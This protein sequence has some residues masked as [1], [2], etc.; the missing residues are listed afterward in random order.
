MELPFSIRLTV[1]PL[2]LVA[3]AVLLL[4]NSYAHTGDFVARSFELKG[5]TL[6]SV[7]L[8]QPVDISAVKQALQARFGDVAVNELSGL[9]GRSILINVD[10]SVDG[11]DVIAVLDSMGISTKDSSIQTLGATVGATFFSQAQTAMAFAFILMAIII[12]S[13]FREPLPSFYMIFGAFSD[14]IITL[15]FMQLFGIELSLASL[16]ALLMLLGYS[17]DTDIMFTSRA[18]KQKDN[19][20]LMEKL[21]GSFKTGITMT[22]TAIV[23]LA[24]ILIT[25]ISPVL[26]QIASVLIIG[27]AADIV[28]TWFLNAPLLNWYMKKRGRA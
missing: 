8:S 14:M 15:G 6:V 17:I 28:V 5:G 3:I 21:R 24:A 1:I 19:T 12:F 7:K 13:I 27:L 23:A 26:V 16:G 18:L 22:G 9:G 4:I 25:S 10:E 11:K 2:A 20:S